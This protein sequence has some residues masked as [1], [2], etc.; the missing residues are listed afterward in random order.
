MKAPLISWWRIS[1]SLYASLYYVEPDCSMLMVDLSSQNRN[2]SKDK[3]CKWF[4]ML[5]RGF[6]STYSRV[7]LDISHKRR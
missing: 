3:T 2:N 7:G 5:D 4:S 1:L 6:L